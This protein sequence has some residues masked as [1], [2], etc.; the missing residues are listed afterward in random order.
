MR[1][2]F[3]VGTLLLPLTGCGGDSPYVPI[4]PVPTVRRDPPAVPQNAMDAV[5]AAAAATA[6]PAPPPAAGEDP[7]T[8]LSQPDASPR[9]D[10]GETAPR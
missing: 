4:D 9:S 7:R 5:P 2:A 1:S 8:F 10:A 6:E 3:L